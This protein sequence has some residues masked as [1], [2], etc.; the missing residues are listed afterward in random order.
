MP[1]EGILVHKP[2]ERITEEQVQQIHLASLQILVDPGLIC[3]SQQAAE[4]FQTNGAEVK[5]TSSGDSPCWH[6]KNV[7]VGDVKCIYKSNIC[8]RQIKADE[9][10]NKISEDLKNEI[11]RL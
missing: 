10:F 7:G 5:S 9:V 3:F 6:I 11:I 2:Y 4:I 8:M 1:R